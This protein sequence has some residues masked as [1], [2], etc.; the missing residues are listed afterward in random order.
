MGCILRAELDFLTAMQVETQEEVIRTLTSAKER[1]EREKHKLGWWD[2]CQRCHLQS[3]DHKRSIHQ[4]I[5]Q[6]INQSIDVIK[7][8]FHVHFRSVMFEHLDVRET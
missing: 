3:I 8:R 1:L 5:N 4:S 7:C 6:S 2:G